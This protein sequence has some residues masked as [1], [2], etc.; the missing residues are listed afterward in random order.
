MKR[1]VF[2]ALRMLLLLF[3]QVNVSPSWIQVSAANKRSLFPLQN[4]GDGG[5][6][7]VQWSWGLIAFIRR[8]AN[9]SKPQRWPCHSWYVT[10][11]ARFL[12]ARC[13]IMVVVLG[14]FFRW[15]WSDYKQITKANKR[16]SSRSWQY[17]TYAGE[18][19]KD[20]N[21]RMRGNRDGNREK[22]R[23]TKLLNKDI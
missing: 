2:Q 21:M 18:Y 13:C 6:T 15:I 23:E 14:F 20:P 17:F 22:K 4:G 19:R 1:D 12:A 8:A 16:R 9:R 3:T 5:A 10:E 11:T 7:A